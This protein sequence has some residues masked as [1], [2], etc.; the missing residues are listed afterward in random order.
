MIEK[1][2]HMFVSKAISIFSL[3]CV[4]YLRLSLTTLYSLERKDWM[5]DWLMVFILRT[6]KSSLYLY[7]ASNFLTNEIQISTAIEITSDVD[8]YCIQ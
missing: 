5:L 2:S 6:K 3:L 4:C 8:Q 7:C 1:L